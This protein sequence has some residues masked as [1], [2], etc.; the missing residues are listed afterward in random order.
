MEL[1]R[2]FIE[3]YDII[4]SR[5]LPPL[6]PYSDFDVNETFRKRTKRNE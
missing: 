6:F 4:L 1:L 5:C 3:L 2:Q